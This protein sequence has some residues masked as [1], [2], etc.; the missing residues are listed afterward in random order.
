MTDRVKN[1][2]DGFMRP[3][4]F[5]AL[6]EGN[7]LIEVQ[8]SKGKVKV[9]FTHKVNKAAQPLQVK[10]KAL[11]TD[12]KYQLIM[13]GSQAEVLQVNILDEANTLVYTDY[14]D[15]KNSFSKVYDLT[16]VKASN[17]TFEIRNSNEIISSQQF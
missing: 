17:F 11:T 4:N 5:A 2:E 13:V 9:P 8:D 3:Y 6:A 10:V 15:A 7:Y 16:K 14:I 1:E 12:K